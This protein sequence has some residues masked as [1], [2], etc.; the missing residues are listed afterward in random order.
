MVMVDPL[1][2]LLKSGTHD[3]VVAQSVLIFEPKYVEMELFQIH[4]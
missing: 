4:L 1:R 2:V 3:L